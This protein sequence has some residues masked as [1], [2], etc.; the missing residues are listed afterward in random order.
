MSEFA[1]E[2]IAAD[3]LG[4][5]TL[6]MRVAYDGTDLHGFAKQPVIPTVQGA[7]ESALEILLRRPVVTVGAG[8][9]DAGVHAIG[10]VVSTPITPEE[11]PTDLSA[12]ARG[13]NALAGPSVRALDVVLAH[14]G[15]S[16]RFDAVSRTYRYL[17]AVGPIAPLFINRYAYHVARP[18]DLEAMIEGA[19]YLHGEH[20]FKSFC[21]AASAEGQRTFRCVDLIEVSPISTP[22]G[23]ELIEV[24]VRGNAFLHSMIRIIV[25]TL[26]EV[27]TGRRDPAW[28]AEVLAACNREAAG[29]T[30]PPN[31]LTLVDVEYP[32][33]LFG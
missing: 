32:T 17:I 22:F 27:G 31:G 5:P 9:T 15:F 1:P 20:D 29:P 14:P 33:K 21:V 13:I 26:V 30:A 23:E 25:G 8:R 28:V 19:S 11:I 16:A 18:L 6:V 2:I 10:Q 3:A 24:V 4:D 12:F 7:L